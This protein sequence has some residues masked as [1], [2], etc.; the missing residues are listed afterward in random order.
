MLQCDFSNIHLLPEENRALV[1]F[2]RMKRIPPDSP[3]FETFRRAGFIDVCGATQDA[4]GVFRGGWYSV[5]DKGRR[6]LQYLKEQRRSRRVS[7]RRFWI[8]TFIAVFALLVAI[9]SLLLQ[10]LQSTGIIDLAQFL[11]H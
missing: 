10:A 9:L 2:S 11:L 6:Y 5:S 1:R 8:T 4:D 7:A 3:H